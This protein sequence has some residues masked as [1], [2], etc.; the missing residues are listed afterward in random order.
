MDA[1]YDVV[2]VGAGP[3]GEVVADRIVRSGL[4]AAVVEAGA[5]GGEC[6]YWACVPSKALLRPGAAREAARSVDGARQAV[7]GDLDPAAVLARRDRFTGRGEDTGQADW[8][9]GAGIAL[10]R[11]HG[12]VAGERR[13]EVT[14]TDGGVRTLRARLAVV[15]STGT[16]AVLPPVEGL[17]GIG[18]WTNR[19]ATTAGTVPARLVV[20]GGGVVACEMATAWRS[21]GSEVTLLVRGQALLTGWEPCAGEEVARG[22]TGLGVTIR[23]GVSATRVAR[24][25]TTR[26]VTVRTDD[27]ATLVCDEVLAAVGRRP[28]TADLGLENVGLPGGGRLPVDDTCRV[29]TVDGDW[30]YAVGDV[31][32]RAPLTHMAKY[33]ARACA[34]AIA[35]RAAGRPADPGRWRVWSADAD[36]V[37]V[38]QAVF[39]RPEIASVGLTERAAREAG[40][41]VRAVEYRIDDVAG[42]ALYADGYRGHAKLVVDETRGVVVGCTFTGPLASELIHTATVALVGEVPLDRL[43]HAVPAFPTVSEVW[44]RLLEAYGP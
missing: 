37:A 14:G 6:S 23:F 35:E 41:A 31:N 19:E 3:G 22:L 4:T 30:L 2:V 34:A 25:E 26:A 20:I 32:H 1:T 40:I 44:L 7:T 13:V 28:R 16:Q 38:P 27:G 24:D 36:R 12:R 39:T 21:L 9:S 43:W 33:Q 11:G 17:D 18:V 15:L 8:L 10:V 5:V 29:T 42:A